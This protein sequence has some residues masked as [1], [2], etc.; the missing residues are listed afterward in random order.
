MNRQHTQLVHWLEASGEQVANALTGLAPA[1]LQAAPDGEWSLHQIMAHLRDTDKHV[2][3]YR[4]KRILDESAPPTVPVF[5]QVEWNAAH[6]SPDEPLARII[7]DFRRARRA[8]VKR[9]RAARDKDWARYA[10]HP[11]Y[12]SIPIEYIAAHA[13]AHTLEH[14]AQ[15]ALAQEKAVMERFTAQPAP[16]PRRAQAARP[17]PPRAKQGAAPKP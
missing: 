7:A 1:Q 3:L 11:I 10:I 14:L 5:E 2:F 16:A 8:L 6:Y 12:G 15:F 17:R 13:Y 4:I 9:L